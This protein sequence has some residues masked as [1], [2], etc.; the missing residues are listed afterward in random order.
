LSLPEFSGSA[1]L[2]SVT[3]A[4]VPAVGALARAGSSRGLGRPS[5]PRVSG[6]AQ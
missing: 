2:S 1:P 6:P 4:W 5:G 3:D